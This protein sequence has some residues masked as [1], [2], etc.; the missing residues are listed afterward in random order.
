MAIKPNGDQIKGTQKLLKGGGKSGVR[1]R[2]KRTRHR[3]LSDLSGLETGDR[4][5]VNSCIYT[6][7]NNCFLILWHSLCSIPAQNHCQYHSGPLQNI[8]DLNTIS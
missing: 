5:M 2:S 4:K 3:Y 1:R 7:A 8:K 6:A